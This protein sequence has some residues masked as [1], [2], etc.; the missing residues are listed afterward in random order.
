M[1]D[2]LDEILGLAKS[3]T[4]S[5]PSD[6]AMKQLSDSINELVALRTRIE[7]GTELLEN[8][9]KE[10]QRL[11]NEIV[12]AKLDEIGF[13]KIVLPD[14]RSVSYS[15]FYSN[16]INPEHEPEAFDWL[17]ENG[18]GGS[19]KGEATFTYRRADRD[20]MLENLARI[21]EDYGYEAKIKLSVHHSTLRALTREVVE[22]GGVFPPDLFSVYIGRKTEIK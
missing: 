16:K 21:K 7:R 18:H 19:I 12:P 4:P 15:P 22:N 8:L 1:S 3:E 20:A 5:L 10:E 6:A 17:E 11:S 14:G 9:K 2:D 13:T